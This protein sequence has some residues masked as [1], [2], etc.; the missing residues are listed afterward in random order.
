MQA[1]TLISLSASLL[2]TGATLALFQIPSTP[3]LAPIQQAHASTIGGIPVFD[4]PGITVQPSTAEVRAALAQGQ[5][6][7]GV[8]L[9]QGLQ[10]LTGN[11][12]AAPLIGSHLTMPYYSFGAEL[13][14]IS[15]D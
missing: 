8:A 7:A 6:T 12:D 13:G 5:R 4:L 2:I 14:Q 9:L 3:V 1:R 10:G 11:G 15:K